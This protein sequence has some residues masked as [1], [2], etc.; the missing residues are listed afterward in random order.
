MNS[1]PRRPCTT[2]KGAGSRSRSGASPIAAASN[3]RVPSVLSE[4]LYLLEYRHHAHGRG[5]V[6]VRSIEAGAGEGEDCLLVDGIGRLAGGAGGI[7]GP[8]VVRAGD[9]AGAPR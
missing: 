7:R 8:R 9:G 1:A 6:D 4:Y 3:S 2:G 5:L